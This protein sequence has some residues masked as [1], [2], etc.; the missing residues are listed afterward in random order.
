M[1]F[2]IVILM[3]II[4]NEMEFAHEN[5]FFRTEYVDKNT[6]TAV[7]GI[8]VI[9]VVFSH[10]A[11]YANFEGIYDT[12]YLVLREH[13]NQMVVATFLF[14]SG[15]GMMEAF[16]KQA[17]GYLKKIPSKFFTLLLRFDIA[18]CLFGILGTGLD[19]GI[20]YNLKRILL[21]F[22]GWDNLGNS[23]WYIFVILMIYIYIY[24]IPRVTIFTK[25]NNVLH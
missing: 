22:I 12:P 24:I 8:F 1:V 9:L 3:L 17:Q 21:S 19:L 20:D 11:Q 10:Y 23:N 15:Y 16:R 5:G 25:Q 18:V 6:T 14:Y 13:L 2:F 7:N 4:F